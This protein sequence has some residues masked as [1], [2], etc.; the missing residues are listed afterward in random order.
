FL[1][2]AVAAL[3]GLALLLIGGWRNRITMLIA[4]P[5]IAAITLAPSWAPAV[6]ANSILLATIVAGAA[7]LSLRVPD[8]TKF[9]AFWAVA[10]LGAFTLIG[11]K[12][13]WLTVQIA[14]PMIML[15]AKVVNDA[16]VPFELPAVS[17]PQ[18]R[19]YAPRR[20]AQGLAAGGVAVV[21]VFTLRTGV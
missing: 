1:P 3:G 10:A 14:L 15:A 7:V 4:A 19:V 18:F 8:L 21:A 11:R 20:L 9:F 16:I 17:V 6:N 5:A 13:P 12:D 2:L